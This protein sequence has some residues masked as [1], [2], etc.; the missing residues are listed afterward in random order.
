MPEAGVPP[1]M[2]SQPEEDR[3]PREDGLW[4]N[5]VSKCLSSAYVIAVLRMPGAQAAPRDILLATRTKYSTGVQFLYRGVKEVFWV[6][7]GVIELLTGGLRGCNI[8]ITGVLKTI[9]FFFH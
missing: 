5:Y 4:E 8:D 6:I 7:T 9:C 2:R 1:A 3:R